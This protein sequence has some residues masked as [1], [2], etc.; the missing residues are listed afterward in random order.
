MEIPEDYELMSIF[1]TIPTTDDGDLVF[2]YRK[3]VYKFE[4]GNYQYVL[5]ITPSVDEL[6]LIVCD[7]DSK[8]TIVKLI[9]NNV[10]KISIIEDSKNYS[11]IEF[12]Y[13][14]TEETYLKVKLQMR[15][16]FSIEASDINI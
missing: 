11:I 9:L 5:E 15:P 1:Q 14:E 3:S 13:G 10:T 8:Q 4:V 6:K 2:Y 16:F 12:L 7:N